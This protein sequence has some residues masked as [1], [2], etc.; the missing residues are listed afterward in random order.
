MLRKITQTTALILALSVPTVH[1]QSGELNFLTDLNTPFPPGCLS[2]DIPSQPR[3]D[4]SVLVEQTLAVPSLNSQTLDAQVRLTIWRVACADEGFSVVLLRLQHLE[5]PVITVP[6]LWAEAGS[7]EV[8]RHAAQLLGIPGSGPVGATGEFLFQGERRTWMLTVE[9]VRFN[10]A[11]SNAPFFLPENYNETFT[12]ELTWES[13][14]PAADSFFTFQI[15]RFEPDLDPPQ[16]DQTV[17]NG[18][19]SGMWER[20]GAERQ[21]L[22]LQ[23]AELIDSNF[24]FAIFFTY[25]DGQPTWVTGNSSPEAAQPGPVTMDPMVTLSQGAFITDEDQP[26][27]EQVDQTQTKAGSMSIEAIDCNTIRVDYDFTELGKG[28]GSMELNRAIRIAGYDCN[29]WE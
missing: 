19:Y 7:V 11:D 3:T 10:D 18:R 6:H 1:A 14:T 8:P 12:L 5:G 2:I 22:L 27:K 21:A 24:V 4:D 23:I 17:L 28:T 9:P 15:A 20:P 29:P 13:L 26:P 25:L 16:F